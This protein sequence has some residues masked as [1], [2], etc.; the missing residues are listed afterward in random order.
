MSET[1]I[2]QTPVIDWGVAT[3]ALAGQSESGDLHLVKPLPHG[4]LVAVVDALGH[5][6]EAAVAA[7]IAAATLD[8]CARES[9]IALINDC[10]ERLKNTHGVVMSLAWFN[11]R[12]N[13]VTWL[14]VGNVE[15]VLLHA[16]P[17]AA[18]DHESVLLRGGVVGYRLPPLRAAVIPINRGDTLIFATDG[19]SSGFAEKLNLSEPPQKMAEQILARHGKENDDALVLVARYMRGPA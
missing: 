5:G 3:L 1:I 17:S 8:A 15:G 2:N 9:V 19:I 10:H 4:V 11:T 14:G 7:K 16:S 13:T 12:D 6:E 18:S